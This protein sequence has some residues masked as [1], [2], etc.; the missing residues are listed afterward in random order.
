MVKRGAIFEVPLELVAKGLKAI[1]ALPADG[2]CE[3]QGAGPLVIKVRSARLPIVGEGEV[4]PRRIA[5]AGSGTG[6]VEKEGA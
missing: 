1:C 2:Q 5:C 6:L 3:F 4:Y